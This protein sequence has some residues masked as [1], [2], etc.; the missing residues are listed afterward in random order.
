MP[1]TSIQFLLAFAIV[2][3]LYFSIPHRY[4]SVF[5]LVSS[6][7]FY[8]AWSPEYLLLLFFS[9][10][11]A[12]IITIRIEKIEDTNGKKRLVALLVVFHL[13][14]LLFYKYNDFLGEI[15]G[16]VFTRFQIPE[17]L[18]RFDLLLPLGIS[19][20]TFQIVG[21]VL[22]VYHN[23]ISAEKN[24]G[25]FALFVSFFPQLVAGPI[26]RANRLIPQF[27]RH[28]KF[29]YS[30]VK[31]GLILMA[32]G[33]FK[34]MVIADRLA[35]YVAVVYDSPEE[36][37]WLAILL[38][39]YF[40]AYQIYCD[41]SGYTDISIGVAKI[42]GF[43]LTENFRRPYSADSIQNFWA[44]WH[45][46]LTSWFKDYLYF[47]WIRSRLKKAK[48]RTLARLS[49]YSIVIVFLISGLWHGSGWNFVIWGGIHGLLLLIGIWMGAIGS[50]FNSYAKLSRNPSPW[51]KGLKILITFNIVTFTWIFFRSENIQKAL[52][53]LQKLTEIDLSSLGINVIGDKH[54]WIIAVISIVFLEIVQFI[55]KDISIDQYIEKQN[56]IV[57][58]G[59]YYILMTAL[60]FFAFV[61]VNSEFIYG[62]F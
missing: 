20:Y 7:C 27:R 8:L 11:A 16:A 46:S 3:F 51:M 23:R 10:L 34:K 37:T 5:L 58:W 1:Y 32:W 60:T 48:N 15:I 22:D 6:Y 9:T 45:I 38:A 30:R 4:Q 19:Y 53:I 12:F 35:V 57:R 14:L 2:V 36:N 50:R 28:N 62:T 47:P 18:P 17:V 56:T 54:Q 43:E 33:F 52:F 42:L 49:D 21:Y 13:G 55:I 44:R 29:E 59:F 61:H 26:E 31:G 25:T 24:F 39:S 40:F 41:F